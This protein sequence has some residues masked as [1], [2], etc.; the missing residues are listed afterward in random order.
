MVE[1]DFVIFSPKKNAYITVDSLAKT[2]LTT[3]IQLARRFKERAAKNF[4]I[5]NLKN[6]SGVFQLKA[7]DAKQ[8]TTDHQNIMDAVNANMPKM[9]DDLEQALIEQVQ[10]F[11]SQMIDLYHYIGNNAN[12]PAHKGYKMYKKLAELVQ[13]RA[14]AKAQLQAIQ[15]AKNFRYVPY[16]PRTELY[17]QLVQ[18]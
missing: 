2:S 16:T 15:K 8:A 7:V 5:N 12:L 13:N 18:L 10:Q 9:F 11:E 3:N 1:Q 14:K 17:E 6:V 4:L